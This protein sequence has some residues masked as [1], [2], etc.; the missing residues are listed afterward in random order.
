MTELQAAVDR[1]RR[2]YLTD[3]AGEDIYPDELEWEDNVADDEEL[4]IRTC[5]TNSAVLE[6]LGVSD[7]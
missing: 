3:E 4:F 2:F 6:A 7:A 5:L 1:L